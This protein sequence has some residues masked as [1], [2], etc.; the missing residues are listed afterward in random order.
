MVTMYSA[1]RDIVRSKRQGVLSPT[2]SIETRRPKSLN[3]PEWLSPAKTF[4]EGLIAIEKNWD[5]YGAASTQPDILCSAIDLL[6]V[7]ASKLGVKAPEISPTR[8]GG[9]IFEWESDGHELE[10]QLVSSD[11]A[12]YVYSNMSEGSMCSG[13][14][15]TDDFDPKCA[16]LLNKYF[17]S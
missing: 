15:F 6:G 4:L 2:A 8:T 5:G 7:L 10:I 9:V 13:A 1:D 11:A 3:A 17:T 12:S 14:L 16:E